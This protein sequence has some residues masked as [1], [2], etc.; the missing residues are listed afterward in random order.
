MDRWESSK[1]FSRPLAV[2]SHSPLL[3]LSS[4]ITAE[5]SLTKASTAVQPSPRSITTPRWEAEIT[6]RISRS[7]SCIFA[8]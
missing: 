6:R 1:C 7:V 3:F 8:V 5:Q 2:A 4:G